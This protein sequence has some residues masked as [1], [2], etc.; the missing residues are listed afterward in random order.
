MMGTPRIATVNGQKQMSE[1][2]IKT[3]MA[4]AFI[5]SSPEEHKSAW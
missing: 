5:G 4:V 3:A 1:L 2:N